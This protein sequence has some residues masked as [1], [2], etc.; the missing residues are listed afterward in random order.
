M[1]LIT[2]VKLH[3]EGDIGRGWGK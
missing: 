2:K 3:G 1:S